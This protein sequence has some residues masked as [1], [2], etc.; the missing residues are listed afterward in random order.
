[1]SVFNIQEALR[2]EL[3]ISSEYEEFV[4]RRIIVDGPIYKIFLSLGEGDGRLDES[5]E[6]SD[7][8]WSGPPKGAANVLSVV[9]ENEQLNLRYATTVPPGPGQRIRV[10]PPKYLEK[11]LDLWC[12]SRF[13]QSCLSRWHELHSANSQDSQLKLNSKAFSGLREAQ[14]K[15]FDLVTWRTSYLWGPPGTGKTTT[16]GALV[17]AIMVQYPGKRVLLLSTTNTAVDEALIAVDQKLT[18]LTGGQSQPVS[19][20]R[21]CLRIGNHFQATRYRGREHLIPIKDQ[22]LIRQMAELEAKMPEKSDVLAYQQWK[23]LVENVRTKIRSQALDALKNARVAAMTTTR[24]IFTY[25][26]I[27]TVGIYDIIV[28]DEASQVGLAHALALVPL[29]RRVLFAGDPQQLAPIVKSLDVYAKEWLGRSAFVKM[30][31]KA[32]YTCLLDEQS[33]M[34]EPICQVVSNAFYDG[35]RKVAASSK[36]DTVWKSERR[37]FPV[38][39]LGARN[40]YL[41]PTEF[42]SNYSKKYGGHIRYETA[43]LVVKLVGDLTGT[44]DQSDILVLTPYRSQRTLLL[45]LMRNAGY[46]KA[47]V[48]TVHRAQGSQRN[49]VIFD[50]VHASNSFLQ[51][52]EI[53]P[54]L[55]NVALSRAKA[56][57]FLIASKENLLNPVLLQIANILAADARA[58]DP[59]SILDLALAPNFPKC[60]LKK[61]VYI[62]RKNGSII[63]GTVDEI[64]NGDLWLI[65]HATGTRK[66]FIAT[67]LKENAKEQAAQI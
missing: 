32:S 54:R 58:G 53:G 44:L 23:H 52:S 11:L 55:M 20:R 60:A 33:R 43:D 31:K 12:R 51:N 26:E 34:A 16:I 25:D 39:Q 37:T 10:Y 21:K 14:R 49:T 15:A 65:D 28:F 66:R 6:G 27:A 61:K 1:M 36:T 18:E 47:H 7:A 38:L 4:V 45:A 2:E 13:A 24:A 3:R 22:T 19:I 40:A 30:E 56:R 35:M 62:K 50:P 9:P 42:E 29:A 48:S 8:W 67:V 5:L 63:T 17:A 41:V 59:V 46:T 64:K 57:L